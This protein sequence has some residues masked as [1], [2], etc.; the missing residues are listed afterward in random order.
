MVSQAFILALGQVDLCKFKAILVYIV[1]SVT[2]N[3]IRET[4]SEKA[5]YYYY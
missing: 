1:S 3:H 4:L 5:D 2:I